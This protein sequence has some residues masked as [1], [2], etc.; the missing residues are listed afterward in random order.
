MNSLLLVSLDNLGDL[1]F[2]SAL[3]PPLRARFPHAHIALW[4][5][6][7]ASGIA[8]MIPGVD[9]V[10]A[11]DPFWDRAP[12]QGKG[13]LLPFLRTTRDVRRNRH[14]VAV[15]A[16]A[17]WRTAAIVAATRI[18]M[19]IGL[20]RHRNRRWLT[21]PLAPADETRPVLVEMARL[22]GPLDAL[23]ETMK[24]RLEATDFSA[25]RTLIAERL[26][27]EPIAVLHPFASQRARCVAPD[28][29]ADVARA[30]ES[31]G[32]RPL[33][34][35]TQAELAAFRETAGDTG[36]AIFSDRAVGESLTDCALA[37]SLA[38]LFVGHDSGPMHVASAFGVPTVGVFAPGEPARTFPQGVG[39]WRMVTRSTPVEISAS[40]IVAEIAG[41]R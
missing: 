27:A 31:E 10:Y 12:G 18:P 1:V 20:E 40:V 13:P 8:R 24:Y 36:R 16:R 3:L 14:D 9:C 7:Y 32:M 30:L 22:L 2:T 6:T 17:P 5:K 11:S 4:C 19:R 39:P 34:M 41:L 29:W 23:G 15:L 37:I 25:R 28:V 38:R 26:G 35:G 33:I 21:H